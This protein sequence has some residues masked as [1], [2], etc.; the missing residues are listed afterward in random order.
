MTIRPLTI[1][2]AALALGS[3]VVGIAVTAPPARAQILSG[4]DLFRSNCDGCHEL[5]DPEEQKRP[6]KDWESILTR[7][8]KQRGATLNDKECAAVLNYLDSFNRPKREVQWVEAPAKSHTAA[9]AAADSGKLPADWVDLTVGGDEQ[10]PWAVQGDP[11]AKTLY[12]SPLKSAGENQFPILIDN[13]GV[14]RNGSATTRLQLVSGKGAVGAGLVF[15]FRN[16]QTYFGVRISPRDVVLY[17][18]QGGQRALL[19]RAPAALALK[20]WQTLGVDVTGTN[21]TVNL[22]GKPLPLLGKAL[23]GYQ[24]GRVGIHTQGDTVALFDQWQV[25]VR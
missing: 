20:Q 9:F 7:M 19:G 18:V 16:P 21:V 6:R 3:A 4:F 12:L 22:N 13:T 23:P 5:P 25:T 10:V 24:G 2:S 14:V 11:A 1:I 17:E 15:G 8:V